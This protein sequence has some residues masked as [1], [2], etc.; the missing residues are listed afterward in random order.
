MATVY[1]LDGNG[2]IGE[3]WVSEQKEGYMIT[4]MTFD[5]YVDN[6]YWRT[7]IEAIK[8][9]RRSVTDARNTARM[10]EKLAIKKGHAV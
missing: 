3:G 2:C 1:H 4:F 9:L 5:G 7:E 10:M 8:E 6:G